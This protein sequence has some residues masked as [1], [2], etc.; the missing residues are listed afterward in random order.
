MKIARICVMAVVVYLSATL[1]SCAQN[2]CE[3][4][5]T[6]SLPETAIT[7]VE[8]IPAGPFVSPVAAKAV[9]GTTRPTSAAR[10]WTD[11]A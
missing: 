11:G 5:R 9:P 8:Y 1:I 7:S 3:K 6:L 2:A 4:L 10:Q